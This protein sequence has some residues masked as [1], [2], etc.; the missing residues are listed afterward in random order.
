MEIQ[1]LHMRKKR[2]VSLSELQLRHWA[3]ISRP[4]H[5]LVN[6]IFFNGWAEFPFVHTYMYHIFFTLFSFAGHLDWFY[7]HTIVNRAAVN[8]DVQMSLHCGRTL[9]LVTR[10]GIARSHSTPD[11]VFFFRSLHTDFHSGYTIYI[12][13]NS[14]QGL[15]FPHAPTSTLAI[16][17]LDGS[18]SDLRGIESKSGFNLCFPNG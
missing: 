9:N 7:F 8:M 18:R 15:P 17:F 2:P 10:N 12:S 6:V 3:V 16:C 4:I 1:D 14:E 5:I 13:T 11:S